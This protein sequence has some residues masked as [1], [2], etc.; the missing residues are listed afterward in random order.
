MLDGV[1]GSCAVPA[2]GESKALGDMAVTSTDDG[3]PAPASAAALTRTQLRGSSLLLAGKAMAMAVTFT[4]QVIVVNH[5][6][7]ADYGAFA[8]ALT[9]V[10]LGQT[11][12]SF[13]LDRAV[14][15]FLPIFHERGDY[16]RILGTLLLVFG[17]VVSLG[18]CVVLV[19]HLV[20]GPIESGLLGGEGTDR[21]LA[22]QLL[23]VLV[24]MAPIEALDDLIEGVTAVFA[25]AK[26]I[27]FRKYV[28]TP[29]LRL[30]VVVSLV[31]T[32]GGARH[33]AVGYLV[34]SVLGFCVYV[35]AL[36]RVLRRTGILAQL[37]WRDRVVPAREIFSFTLPLL[38]SDLV[39]VV[40]TTTDVFLL[41]RFGGTEDVAAYKAVVPLALLNQFVLQS[42]TLL[43]TPSAARLYARGDS[44]GV[45]ALYW[46]T[47]LWVALASF[48]VFAV[49]FSLAQPVTEL[50]FGARYADSWT[51]LAILSFGYFFNAAL[52]FNGL[53]LKVYGRLR[54]IVT[55]NLVA[56]GANIALNLALIPRYGP[57]GAAIG[58]CCALVLHNVLKQAGLLLGTGVSLFDAGYA[59]A[60]ASIVVAAGTLFGLAWL[61]PDDYSLTS[62]TP[63]VTALATGVLALALFV[64]NRRRLDVASTF[65]G[66]LRVPVVG[67]LLGG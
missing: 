5:L 7:K 16:G 8:Y 12:S 60:Y 59:R 62:P 22:V 38:S 36:L 37:R 52:G 33:L 47:A 18:L 17:S 6:T 23:L 27:F 41:A 3:R 15:R 46:R 19:V 40:M 24:V 13:G 10:V 66:L 30:S 57:I 67:R 63:Y 4:I 39:M 31:V 35:S 50:L 64:L 21:A 42:Y 29:A 20:A 54:Y 28:L 43:Y 44:A 14:T 49:S 48:P 1:K 34:A 25:S 55:I 65:P 26:V 53:T 32:D 9:F 51:I 61:L 56:A 58:T 2:H 11:L 45:N